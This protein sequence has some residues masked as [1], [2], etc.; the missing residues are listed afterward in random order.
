M[1]IAALLTTAKTWKQLNCPA[2]DDWV[3][4]MSHIHTHIHKIVLSPRNEIQPYTAMKMNPENII[5]SEKSQR[6]QIL[7][8]V[9]YIWNLNKCIYKTETDLQK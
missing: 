3:K 8:D 1:F 2:I 7:Y 9:N 6:R 4:K 5:L